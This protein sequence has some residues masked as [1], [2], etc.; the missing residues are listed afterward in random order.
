METTDDALLTELLDDDELATLLELREEELTAE[1][2]NDELATELA[3]LAT[4]EEVTAPQLAAWLVLVLT[5][6]R[7][8]PLMTILVQPLAAT[9]AA[10]NASA[11]QPPLGSILKRGPPVASPEIKLRQISKF[12]VEPDTGVIK[13]PSA[14]PL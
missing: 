2:D 3:L 12:V 6:T 8:L 10:G 1:D 5:I 11:P 13:S 4:D 9:S 14:Q 7:V